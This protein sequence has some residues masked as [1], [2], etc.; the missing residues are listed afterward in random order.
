MSEATILLNS[1]LT[2]GMTFEVSDG[3]LKV[4]SPTRKILPEIKVKLKNYK[5]EIISLLE[6][7][8]P[9][10]YKWFD[11]CG[12]CDALLYEA[13]NQWFCSANCRTIKS[14]MI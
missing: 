6:T 13:R 14:L 3:K 5:A 10:P 9:K 11:H 1:L 12:N 8:E 2:S 7:K 4:F